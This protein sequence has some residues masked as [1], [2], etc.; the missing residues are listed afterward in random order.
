MFRVYINHIKGRVLISGR[1]TDLELAKQGWK[2][3]YKTDSWKKAYNYARKVALKYDYILEW[4]LEEMITFSEEKVSTK[5]LSL[6]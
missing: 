3:I 5:L 4:Y 6:N 1:R 2:I